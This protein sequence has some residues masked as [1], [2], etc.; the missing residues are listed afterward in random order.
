MPEDELEEGADG[1]DRLMDPDGV[2]APIWFQ[3]VPERKTLKNRLHLDLDVGYADGVKLPYA[4][5]RPLVEQRVAELVAVGATVLR[6]TDDS[7]YERF[8]VVL[9]DPEGNEFCVR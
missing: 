5:S 3:P 6:I 4:R 2:G 1:T 9:A 7:R 8:A